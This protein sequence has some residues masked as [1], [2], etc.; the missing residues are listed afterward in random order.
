MRIGVIGLG[1][2]GLPLAVAFAEAGDVVVGGRRRRAQ[3]R[4]DRGRPLVHRGRPLRAPAG[5]RG[6]SIEASTHFAPLAR[7]RR[8]A[9]LRADAADAQPRARPRAAARRPARRSAD[10]IQRGQLVV[11]ES[12]TYPGT[13]REQLVPLLEQP[14]PARRATDFNLAFSPERVDPGRTDYTL[15]NTPKVVGG[16]HARVHRARRRAVR[17]GLRPR[18]PRSRR[19]EVAEM[20][21]LLENIFRSVNI[22]LVNELA[23][24]AGPHGHRHLGGRRRRLHQALRVHALR[25]R[26]GHGRPLPAGRP[27]LPHLAG[28]RVPHGHRVHRA[29]RQGQPAD[30]LLLRGADRARAQRRE[31]AGQ[32]LADPRSS[33]PATRAASATS[34][35]PPRCGSSSC[36]ASAARLVTYHDPYVPAL[37]ELGLRE[38][39]ARRRRRRRRRGR[40][41]H[42]APA[43]STT[44]RWSSAARCSSTCAASP[45]GYGWTTWSG[46]DALRRVESATPG[47]V[48]QWESARFTRERSLVRAQPCPSKSADLDRASPTGGHDL[49][50]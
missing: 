22:A 46:S 24:L 43:A 4:G 2:V 36:S 27:V 16:H 38:R 44:Q 45:A 41:G 17:A 35:S 31:Q 8:G 9:D 10:V 19:P 37:P 50:S 3:D 26:P 48:A 11:L 20:T 12:T 32:G 21:K 33:A 47:R 30:A 39:P 14:R 29:R 42:R 1:Y 5:G 6:R 23:M 15:R 49:P 7:D 25:A 18:G 34:A 13:T 40:A 28:A